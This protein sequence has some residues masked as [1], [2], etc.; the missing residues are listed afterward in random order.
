MPYEF[1]II[2]V[3]ICYKSHD[4]DIGEKFGTFR[5]EIRNFPA[6]NSELSGEKYK[7][8]VNNFLCLLTLC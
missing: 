3:S 8:I 5:R 6:R 7:R 4:M 2:T 1:L